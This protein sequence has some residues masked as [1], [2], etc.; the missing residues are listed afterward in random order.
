MSNNG[1]IETKKVPESDEVIIPRDSITEDIDNTNVND[2]QVIVAD[3][4]N[5]DDYSK[6]ENNCDNNDFVRIFD[7]NQMN[8]PRIEPEKV[9]DGI[10][11]KSEEGYIAVVR[12]IVDAST[13]QLDIQNENK[14]DIRG[15]L[16]KFFID[17]L[18]IQY[19]SLFLLLV[20]KGFLTEFGLS[21]TVLLAFITSVFVE[22]LG[23]VIIMIRFA[24]DSNQEINALK[25]LHGVIEHYQKFTKKDDS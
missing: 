25:I 18:N 9:D 24:F 22:T 10:R 19:V 14:K 2:E 6:S 5:V 8:V 13:K 20:F 12:D 11:K 7:R 23:A 1:Q 4:E 21:D 3:S 15:Q 16:I 17:F